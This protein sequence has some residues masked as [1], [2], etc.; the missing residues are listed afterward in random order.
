MT[1]QVVVE[2]LN[3]LLRGQFMGI[4]SFEHYIQSL[5]EGELKRNFQHMQQ[6]LKQNA[7]EIAE[8]IQNLGGVPADD[9]GVSGSSRIAVIETY[10]PC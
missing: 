4:R 10:Y 7:V 9:E 5:D 2:E 8:R 6:D 3:T 1:T